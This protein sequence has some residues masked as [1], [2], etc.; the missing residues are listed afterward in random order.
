MAKQAAL[1]APTVDRLPVT[2]DNDGHAHPDF[3]L[4]HLGNVDHL[5][6]TVR[7]CDDCLGT[8]DDLDCAADLLD[9]ASLCRE[10]YGP[11]PD[12]GVIPEH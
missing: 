9:A 12:S 1:R 7:Q 5:L 6:R 2:G 3:N 11:A 4:N 8:G 10:W